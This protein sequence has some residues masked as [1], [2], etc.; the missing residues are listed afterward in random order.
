MSLVPFPYTNQTSAKRR[1]SAVISSTAYNRL[2]QDVV[3]IAVTSNLRPDPAA[4]DAEI[5]DWKKAGL[6]KPSAFKPII[7]TWARDLIIKGLGK[8]QLI[9]Q[10]ILQ[11]L[12]SRILGP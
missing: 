5:L 11:K 6:V 8:L 9:D 2:R 1:P 7:T 3:L 10:E 12:L 4:I